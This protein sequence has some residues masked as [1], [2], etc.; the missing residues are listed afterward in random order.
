M[1]YFMELVMARAAILSRD[2]TSVSSICYIDELYQMYECKFFVVLLISRL[3]WRGE[4]PLLE[5]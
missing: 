3:L 5:L 2:I 1:K 4:A